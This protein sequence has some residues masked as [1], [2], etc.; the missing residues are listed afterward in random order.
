V[1]AHVAAGGA[2]AEVAAREKVAN[3]SERERAVLRLLADGLS[4]RQIARRLDIVE[5][6][7]KA[8]VSAVLTRLGVP[9]RAAAAVLAA[10]AGLPRS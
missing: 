4:N 2:G 1:V 8:H 10:Q 5:S 6:T 3:L 7:V 9:N